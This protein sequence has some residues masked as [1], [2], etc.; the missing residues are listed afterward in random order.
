VVNSAAASKVV[1]AR[2]VS[3]VAARV[4]SKVAAARA[5]ASLVNDARRVR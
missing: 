3:K 1:A 5:V 2:V 4:V